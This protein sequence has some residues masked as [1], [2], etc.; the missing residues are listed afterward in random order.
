M[1]AL[2]LQPGDEVI[3]PPFTFIATAEVIRLL[4]VIADQNTRE[5]TPTSRR[6]RTNG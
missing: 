3:T 5:T 4:V 6:K 2:E 1:M